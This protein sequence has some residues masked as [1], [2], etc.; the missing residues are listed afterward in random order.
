MLPCTSISCTATFWQSVLWAVTCSLYVKRCV[1][2]A[3]KA[4]GPESV[5]A[6]KLF[7]YPEPATCS[8]AEP[9]RGTECGPG[10]EQTGQ[11][12][13]EVVKGLDVVVADHLLNK[14]TTLHCKGVINIWIQV[15][16]LWGGGDSSMRLCNWLFNVVANFHSRCLRLRNWAG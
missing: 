14:F 6:R 2:V 15:C 4:Q 11:Q 10:V 12:A 16:T 3:L 9:L 5:H 8:I 7:W 1:T 13:Q